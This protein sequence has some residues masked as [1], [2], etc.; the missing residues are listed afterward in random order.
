MIDAVM[1]R[2]L[3]GMRRL[4]VEFPTH[5]FGFE[6]LLAKVEATSPLRSRVIRTLPMPYGHR[7]DI[8]VVETHNHELLLRAALRRGD[9]TLAVEVVD[10]ADVGLDDRDEPEV[11]TLT[12]GDDLAIDTEE[13]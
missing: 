4:K 5:L 10:P 12:T 8:E 3:V 13:E 11:L 7:L 1:D 6:P 2:D 9:K